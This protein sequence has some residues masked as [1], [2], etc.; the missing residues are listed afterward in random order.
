MAMKYI[1]RI[2]SKEKGEDHSTTQA[3]GKERGSQ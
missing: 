2:R 3:R 1:I